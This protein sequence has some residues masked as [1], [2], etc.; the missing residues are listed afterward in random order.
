MCQVDAS[1]IMLTR[2]RRL[3][4]KGRVPIDAQVEPFHSS[5]SPGEGAFAR[6]PRKEF[7]HPQKL[8]GDQRRRISS[9]SRWGTSESPIMVT[10]RSVEMRRQKTAILSN[11]FIDHNEQKLNEE[12][13]SL[14]RRESLPIASRRVAASSPAIRPDDFDAII[15]SALET[16]WNNQQC[17]G[18]LYPMRKQPQW[19][20]LF[21]RE[22]AN[23][24]QRA[25]ST[26]SALVWRGAVFPC[27]RPVL[28]SS[29]AYS[30]SVPWR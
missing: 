26:K 13:A 22:L 30:D 8:I 7:T 14:L 21:L 1:A 3:G 25:E 2:S 27:T 4:F 9:V 18:R 19:R 10:G 24:K 6:E 23:V 11:I 12:S 28:V 15:V 29:A 5:S 17:L 20:E 16:L